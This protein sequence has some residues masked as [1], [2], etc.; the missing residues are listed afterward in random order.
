V[1]ARAV[2][3]A[4]PEA[5]KALRSQ[6]GP[7]LGAP[8]P[9]NFL[10]HA[11][12]QTVAGIAA[13]LRAGHEH[14]LA[15][16]D[17]SRWGVLAAPRFLAR[18]NVAQALRRFMQEGAWGVSPHLIPHRSLHSVSGSVSQA[19]GIHG[20]NFGVGGGPESA[21]KALLAAATMLECEQV[22]GVW[23]VLTGWNW[24]PGLELASLP[25]SAEC[26]RDTPAICSAAAMALLPGRQPLRGMCWNITGAPMARHALSHDTGPAA[27][28]SLEAIC[29]AF[30][31]HHN[32]PKRWRLACGGS[33]QLEV[34]NTVAEKCA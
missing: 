28:L 5:L 17:F 32:A 19:L 26:H 12:E 33:A 10:K 8:L 23:L 20:P 4:S 21:A 1:V 31:S 11:D 15:G 9:V 16:V 22:P 25:Q 6:P 3:R 24:E 13:V 18:A 2:V 29:D 14:G 34:V 7:A 27:S 30:E